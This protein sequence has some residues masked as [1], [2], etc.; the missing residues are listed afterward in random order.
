[1]Q[2]DREVPGSI[3]TDAARHYESVYPMDVAWELGR[4][5]SCD[6]GTENSRQRGIGLRGAA[7]TQG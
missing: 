3:P 4:A 5:K 6:L 2:Q 7:L 1:M